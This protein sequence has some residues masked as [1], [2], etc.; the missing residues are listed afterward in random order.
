ML[1]NEVEKEVYY[2]NRERIIDICCIKN[3]NLYRIIQVIA[4]FKWCVQINNLKK[5]FDV[6]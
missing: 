3:E 4:I 5:S 6:S 1:A 2:A